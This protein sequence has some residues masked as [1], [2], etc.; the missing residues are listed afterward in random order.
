MGKIIVKQDYWIEIFC[1]GVYGPLFALC[2]ENYIQW[3]AR[4]EI[5]I[6]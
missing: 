5:G 3:R 6:H 2:Q 1:W 4:A